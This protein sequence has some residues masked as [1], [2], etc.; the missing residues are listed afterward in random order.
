MPHRKAVQAVGQNVVPALQL[1]KFGLRVLRCLDEVDDWSAGEF[2]TLANAAEEFGLADAD[3]DG[4]FCTT[5]PPHL[6]DL[7]LERALTVHSSPTLF[8]LGRVVA[9]PGALTLLE[10]RESSTSELLE[11][12]HRGIW[13]EVSEDD[14]RA[15]EEALHGGARI[16]SVYQFSPSERIWII[17]EAD[18]SAT[19]LLLPEEY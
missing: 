14:A 10:R 2:D 3:A 9:T 12:H 15:N 1:A 18:R 17:T 19:T 4:L 13:G 5:V 6:G 8:P 16:F 11:L 7:A